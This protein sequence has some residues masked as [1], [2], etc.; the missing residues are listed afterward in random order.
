MNRKPIT[1][2]RNEYIQK[3]CDVTNSV[4]LPAFV[5]ADVVERLLGELRKMAESELERDT[6]KYE[7]QK[8]QEQKDECPTE[9]AHNSDMP[10]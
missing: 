4:Q 9:E 7:T 1:V 8:A 3:L 10:E 5:K 6:R 2:T